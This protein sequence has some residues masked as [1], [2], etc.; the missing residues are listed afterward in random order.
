ME[1]GTIKTLSPVHLFLNILGM[2]VFPFMAKP[3][4]CTV[5]EFP[6]PAF[7]ALMM[8]RKIVILDFLKNALRTN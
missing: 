6:D 3:I 7:E 5:F 4:F 8:E 2:T 1:K